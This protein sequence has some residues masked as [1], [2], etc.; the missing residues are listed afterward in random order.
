MATLERQAPVGPGEPAP[1]FTLPAADREGFFS[2][3]D[4][5]GR[6]PLLLTLNRGLWCPFCRRHIARLGGTRA[7]LESVGVETL[8][9]VATKPER[10]RLY[11]RF[12]AASVPLAADPEL[13]THRSY[14][15]PKPVLTPELLE[16]ARSVR[17][18]PAGNLPEPV[19]LMDVN[20][21]ANRLDGFEL[22][23]T[24]RDDMELQFATGPQTHGQ[25]LIDRDGIVR[26]RNIEC[27][28]GLS[29]AGRYPTDEDLLAAARALVG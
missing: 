15:L 28:E 16:A 22:T 8:A 9:V 23:D 21:V 2:L 5:R 18:N 13:S 25:F 24:D 11:L 17:V 3:A 20:D 4:Y 12:R 27:A 29:G 10:A 14:G 7:K 19:P 26:W 6:S 1:D